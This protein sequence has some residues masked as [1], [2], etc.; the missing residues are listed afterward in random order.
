MAF[1]RNLEKLYEFMRV[2]CGDYGGLEMAILK[3]ES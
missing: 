2:R 1:S 3:R